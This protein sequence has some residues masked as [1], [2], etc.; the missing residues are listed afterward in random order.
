M[1]V[2]TRILIS[3]WYGQG[4]LGDEAVLAGMLHTINRAEP[5]ARVTVLSDDPPR[6]EREHGVAATAR[7]NSGP[8][9]RLFSETRPML[10]SDAFVL[11]G[12]G[13]VKDF[14]NLP[15]NVHGWVRP[16]LVARA[17]RRKTMWYAIGVDDLRFRESEEYARRAADRTHL[18]TVRDEGSARKLAATGVRTDPLITAD[19]AIVLADPETGPDAGERLVAVCPRHW[20]EAAA[21][22]ER[23]ELQDRL[24]VEVAS[25]LD[26]LHERFG[27]RVAF[28]PFR[29]HAEDDDREVCAAIRERMRHTE[30]AT[31]LEVPGSPAVAAA[32]LSR[33]ELV[34]GTRLHS[35]ILAA[36]GGTPFHALDYMPKVRFFCER[37]GLEGERSGIEEASAPGRLTAVLGDAFERR[38]RTRGELR[39]A[40]P[41]LQRLAHINAELLAALVRGAGVPPLV[42]EARDVDRRLRAAR[43]A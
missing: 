18:L 12:G 9:R 16:G 11:G 1:S 36:A 19:P 41:L 37:V 33:C 38:E 4:N 7:D 35:L 32:F 24:Y 5:E 25:A 3:G 30:A 13:L 40:V 39:A 6:T 23:P 21:D 17:L 26:S 43:A 8:R 27:T 34:V 14:G 15:G 22:V 10:R 29:S 20:K 42:E 2:R 31:T 28:V